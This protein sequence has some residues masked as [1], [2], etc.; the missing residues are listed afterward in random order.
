MKENKSS[1]EVLNETKQIE[2]FEL[3]INAILQQ[4]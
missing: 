4:N 1:D 3:M 2:E